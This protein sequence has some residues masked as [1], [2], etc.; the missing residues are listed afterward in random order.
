MP[1]PL[2]DRLSGDV[3]RQRTRRRWAGRG[4]LL[5][6]V[7][8]LCVLGQVS[9]AGAQ[10]SSPAVPAVASVDGPSAP[11]AP[12]VIVR[13]AATGRASVRAVRVDTPIKI[14]GRM[15]EP[16]YETVP[17][18]GDFI[19]VEPRPGAPAS[20]RTDVWV[21]FDH[22]Q[23]YVT[24]RSWES[25]PERIVAN[26]LRRDNM[27]ILVGND[28]VGFVF[29]TFSDHRNGM[30]FGANAAGGRVDGQ[31]TNLQYNG[32]YNPI[33]DVAVG[34]FDGGWVFEAAVPFK[35]L[36]YRP[37]SDQVWGFNVQRST[38]WRNEWTYLTR[39]PASYAQRGIM[40]TALAATLVGI[41]VPAGSKNLEIKPYAIASLA[42]D[43]TVNP[44][45]NNSLDGN[46]GVDVKYG[47]TRNL[48][49]DLT[50]KTDFAQVE[51][52]E[53]QVNLTRF[54]LF[55]PEKREFFL[56]N[57]GT[58]AFGGVPQSSAAGDVPILF[59][60]RRV[61]LDNG[62]AVPIQGGGRLTGRVGR[63]N[64]GV[65]NIESAEETAA[66][67]PAANFSVLRVKRDVFRRSS[68]GLLATGRTNTQS[69]GTNQMYG[70]DGTFLLL[71]NINVNTYWAK[72]RSD[73]LAGDDTSYRAQLDYAADRYG[74]Q[75]ERLVVGDHF[76]PEVGYVR[77]DNMRKSFGLAR[78]SP[79]PSRRGAIR[80]LVSVGS[81]SY[82]ENGG[83]QLESRAQN[84]EFDVEFQSGDKF[85]AVY[86]RAYELLVRPFV[87]APGVATIPVGAYTFSSVKTGFTLGPKRPLS[88]TA[89]IER[90]SFYDGNKTS[91][92]IS[93]IRLQITPRLSAEPNI[94][95]NWIEVAG[96][97]FTTRLAG[98]RIT[99][100]A[101]PQMFVSALIQHN[102]STASVSANVR[103]R[104]EYRPGSELFIVYN[105]QRDTG[106]RPSSSLATRALIVKVNRLFRF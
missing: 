30:L 13:D 70:V 64:V 7:I 89:S 63:Y 27:N 53:Q 72:T 51:A 57:Q 67:L 92:I 73:A 21:F 87:I 59:Y 94:T 5:A 34:R 22:R 81:V 20:E 48:T 99:Y 2:R 25:Q 18:M 37:G 56:E 36:R 79:R 74:L 33:W 39:I 98:S 97:A 19:Q 68:I 6:A 95:F 91:L 47:V 46:L 32:D 103:L 90:G 12:A 41:E 84:G 62:R 58:F 29:D 102:T 44:R 65:L 23:I 78:F 96:S 8:I 82:I 26:E 83:G 54:N 43:A 101:T 3:G 61:G 105:E 71:D 40:Q 45:V 15:D 4:V 49:A 88:G 77:R 42:T 17:A 11:I 100:T 60:S 14:D 85:L 28:Q 66:H 52:D 24:I 1:E 9:P 76:N 38:P 75:L 86:D 55:F 93:R 10:P 106:P 35:T 31:F 80:R 104:W 16:D 50:Y 69:G